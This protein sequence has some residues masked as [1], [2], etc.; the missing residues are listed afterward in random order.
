VADLVRLER[1]HI[2]EQF[3]RFRG[4]ARPP[5]DQGEVGLGR[6]PLRRELDRPA[7]QMLRI[8]PAPDPRRQL[9]QHADRRDVERVFLEVRLQQPLGDVEPV[10]VHRHRRLDQARMPAAGYGCLRRHGKSLAPRFRHC[11][12]GLESEEA[13][14]PAHNWIASSLCSSQ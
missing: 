14:Q 11:D 8:A 2:L 10:L 9:A 5:Q 7:Q 12:P 1:E 6:G 4:A 13:I 3:H